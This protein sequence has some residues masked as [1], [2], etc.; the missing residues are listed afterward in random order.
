MT[1]LDKKTHEIH[2]FLN[3]TKFTTHTVALLACCVV[4]FEYLNG[5]Q[6]CKSCS[7]LHSKLTDAE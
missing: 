5:H 3:P 6:L 7:Y 4:A 2:K 1:K